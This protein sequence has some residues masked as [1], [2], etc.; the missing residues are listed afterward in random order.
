MSRAIVLGIAFLLF[1]AIPSGVYTF[2]PRSYNSATLSQGLLSIERDWTANIVIIGYDPSLIDETILVQGLPE[3]RNYV[4]DTVSITHNINYQIAYADTNYV[5]DLRQEMLDNSINGTGTGTQLNESALIYQ[6]NNL[7]EPQRIFYPRDGRVI[8]GYAIEDWLEEN[9]FLTPPN[10]GYTLYLV[11]FSE[12]D[13]ADHSLEH[14]YDY[15]PSDADT[16]EKQD[17]FRLEWDN[18]LNPDVTMDHPFFGGRYNTY[19]VDPSAHQWYLKWCRIWWNE[20]IGTEYDFWTQDLEDKV[21]SLNFTLPSDVDALNVYLRECIW[22]PITQLL[23]P[24]QHQPASFVNSGKLRALILCMDVA[25]GVSI[26]SLEWVTNAGMQK[27]HL[28]ELYPFIPWEVDVEYLDIDEEPTWNNLFWTYAT[29]EPDGT[30]VADGGAMFNAIYDIMKPDYV[31]D[32]GNINVFGVVF[33]KKQMEMQVYGGTY[34]GLGGGGQTVI[35]KSWERYYRPDEVTPKD[36]ISSVQLHETMH[37]IGFHHS[38]QHEHYASDFQWGPM[39]YFAYHNGTSSFDKNWVQGTYLDQME[40]II[41]DS[42]I[43]NQTYLGL[44]ERDATYLAED[45]A[46]AAFDRA[47][48]SYNSM[49]W[50]AA[51]EAL[52]DA[53]DWTRRMRYSQLDSTPPVILDWGTIPEAIESN[54]FTY[55]AQITDDMAGIEN[56]T[57]YVQADEGSINSFPLSFTGDNWTASIPAQEH[58]SN[59]TMWVIAWDWGM[60]M[61]QGGI[62]AD[63]TYPGPFVPPPD[64]LLTLTIMASVAAVVI[65]VGFYVIRRRE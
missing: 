43:D 21:G 40:A 45:R 33:I 32:D 62:I 9:P 42:F 39:G 48:N 51:F 3:I 47:R 6:K 25:D 53:R 34:T 60:N 36:G 15:H 1:V 55:W 19:I 59:L 57:L 26:E 65:V 50:L 29:V 10:L 2:E 38:W 14:W 58:D 13:N 37:A 5:D 41:W 44:N 35:W 18:A 28:E 11:N 64:F 52:E 46:I 27:G 54:A 20:S 23:F 7:D 22:D 30:T 12:F 56:A 8:D 4:T 24:Y 17:W 61:V 16:G 31:P 49:D 63:F